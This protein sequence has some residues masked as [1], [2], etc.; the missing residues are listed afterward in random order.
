MYQPESDRSCA[1]CHREIEAKQGHLRHKTTGSRI[2]PDC[3]RRLTL[4]SPKDFDREKGTNRDL[5]R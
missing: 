1:V 3:E 4:H 2:C 5:L